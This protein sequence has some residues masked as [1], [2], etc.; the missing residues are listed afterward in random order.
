MADR[1][2]RDDSDHRFTD[3]EVALL[4]QRAAEI[5]AQRADAPPAQG[6]SLR[7]LREIATEVGISDAVFD[8]AVTAVQAGAKP[9]AGAPAGEKK[10]EP[11]K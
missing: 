8:E 5:E 7:Q 4:L 2:D 6:M 9:A 3:R 10:A 1:R 11:K